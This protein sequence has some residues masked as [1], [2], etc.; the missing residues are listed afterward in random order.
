MEP[1]HNR[2]RVC[3]GELYGFKCTMCGI[4]TDTRDES[5]TC[6]PERCEAK[7]TGCGLVEDECS[8]KLP[9]PEQSPHQTV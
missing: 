1:V 8:C 5:H 6:G 9:E 2:C 7:C 3:G 4:E